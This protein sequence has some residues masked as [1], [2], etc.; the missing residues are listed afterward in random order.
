MTHPPEKTR[1]LSPTIVS[2]QCVVIDNFLAEEQCARL[3]SLVSKDKFFT[4]HEG[5]VS[6]VWRPSDGFPLKSA[7]RYFT[8]KEVPKSLRDAYSFYPFDNEFDHL[9]ESIHAELKYRTNLFGSEGLDWEGIVSR[10]YIYPAGTA[11]SLHT[12]GGEKYAG[13]FIYYCQSTWNVHWGGALIVLDQRTSLSPP[14]HV[15][16]WLDPSS[17]HESAMVPGIGTCIFPRP[18]RLVLLAPNTLHFISRV[19][20]TAGSASRISI[21]GFLLRK[22]IE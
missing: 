18:N 17:E 7:P 20:T 5:E 10:H 2:D 15:D 19:D 9:F 14:T 8:E 3:L 1:Q 12:D 21:A 6:K 22:G 13:G 4:C 11:L 16:A